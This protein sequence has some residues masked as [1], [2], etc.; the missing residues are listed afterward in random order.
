MVEERERGVR[1]AFTMYHDF[2]CGAHTRTYTHTTGPHNT[3][4]WKPFSSICPI[5]NAKFIPFCVLHSLSLPF[6]YPRITFPSPSSFHRIVHS[7][8]TVTFLSPASNHGKGNSDTTAVP[9]FLLLL[10]CV[11]HIMRNCLTRAE[12]T[13]VEERYGGRICVCERNA[14]VYDTR[15]FSFW[16]GC[17]CC[18][19][20]EQSQR[21]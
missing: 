4:D 16:N 10:L 21:C 20:R 18:V 5:R 6:F 14:C 11:C 19:R 17:L 15:G 3:L 2:A 13:R 8:L 1:Q 7:I 12:P 9:S